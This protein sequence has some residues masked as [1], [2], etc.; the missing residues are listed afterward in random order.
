M[1][2]KAIRAFVESVLRYGLPPNFQVMLIKP[3]KGKGE[4]CRKE[5]AK[6]YEGLS[7]AG[8][9]EGEAQAAEG[10]EAFYPYVSLALKSS[11]NSGE[12]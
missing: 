5:L 6:L 10:Q 9:G 2:L 3:K 1:H 7:G 8:A 11:A 12:A 4:K